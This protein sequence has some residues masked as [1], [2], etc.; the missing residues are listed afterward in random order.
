LSSLEPTD[1]ESR[2]AAAVLAALQDYVR[3]G[4]R[5]CLPAG[6]FEGSEFALQ[7]VGATPNP[8]G[9]V[10]GPFRYQFE[11]EDDLLH[12][13]VLRIDRRELTVEDGQL[14]FAFLLPFV[15]AGLVWVKPGTYSQHFYLGHEAIL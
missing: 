7:S 4:E 15:P 11:G 5:I 9:G 2:H 12:L 1:H 8:F 3:R 6:D 13:F 14:V 10:V